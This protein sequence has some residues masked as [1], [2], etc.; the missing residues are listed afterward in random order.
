[1][2]RPMTS[3]LSAKRE[4]TLPRLARIFRVCGYL[5][6]MTLVLGGG[7]LGVSTAKAASGKGDN[8]AILAK[9]RAD[10]A[11]RLKLRA[12]DIKVVETRAVTW[13]DA[14]LGMPRIDKMY[15]QVLTPGWRIVFDARS[16]RYLYTA[17]AKTFSYGGPVDL[18]SFSMLYLQPVRDDPDMNGDLYQ[19]SL[20]GTNSVRLASGMS[21]YY[22]QERGVVIFSRRTSRSSFDL[23]YVKTTDA[24]KIITLSSAFD[25]GA[26]AMNEAQDKW[27]AFSRP[28]VGTAWN[29]VVAP[30][31]KGDAKE[32][33]LPL[34][35]GT[36]PDRI[37][38]SGDQII[39]LV[40]K[41]E[42][43]AAYTISPASATPEWKAAAVENYPWFSRFMLNKSESLEIT[44]VKENGKPGVEVARVWFTGDRKVKATISG[45]TLR[46]YDFLGMR[47]A[48]IRG[49]RGNVPVVYTVDIETGEVIPAYGEADRDIKPF[50]YP[51]T[52]KP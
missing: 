12:Q 23:L 24:K 6:V 49:E 2:T 25:F 11:Q 42:K 30:L 7:V 47:F 37:A 19:C 5:F 43:T 29:V 4:I 15:A 46:N 9:C 28:M 27:A 3:G 39:I 14:A 26:A 32:Q 36:R 44:Q 41:G 16:T 45:V 35:D 52:S 50:E 38:W 10:L 34:P 13:H 18:W 33:T 1:M 51:P 17:S 21:E 40:K 31:A 48:Y 22:P 20:L 8:P